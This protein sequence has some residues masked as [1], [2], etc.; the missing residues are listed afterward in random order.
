MEVGDAV[1]AILVSLL[2]IGALAAASL[3]IWAL[4]RT[5]DWLLAMIEASGRH[6]ETQADRDLRNWEDRGGGY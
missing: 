6:S 3:L 2:P 1:N 5:F 4:I